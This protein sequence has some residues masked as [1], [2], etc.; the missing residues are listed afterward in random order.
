M[1]FIPVTVITA[2]ASSGRA[3]IE[4]RLRAVGAVTPERAVVMAPEGDEVA[5]LDEAI[6]LG[7]IVRSPTGRI[8]LN[9][10]AVTAGG[11][12]TV[13]ALLLLLLVAASVLVSV[14]ALIAAFEG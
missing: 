8:Y 7:R 9:A 10:S 12:E 3:K 2:G 14:I 11:P 1:V 4:A 6:G 5:G 13:F